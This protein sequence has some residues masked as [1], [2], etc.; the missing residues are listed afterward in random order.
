[1]LRVVVIPVSGYINRLQAIASA[2]LL[3]D[4]IGAEL[5]ICWI[6]DAVAPV[7][8]E[9]VL[10]ESLCAG[11]LV[12]A[13]EVLAMTGVNPQEVPRYLHRAG[14]TITL[15]GHDRGEQVFM[16]ELVSMLAAQQPEQLVIRA[17]GRY[18]LPLRGATETSFRRRRQEFYRARILA[19]A[20]EDE[21]ARQAAQHEP[22]IG[23]HLRYTDRAHQAPTT[24]AT[25]RALDQVVQRTGIRSV[26]IASDTSSARVSW[27]NRLRRQGL[28]PWT[29]AHDAWDRSVA[30]SEFSAMVDWRLLTRSLALIY[31]A[32]SS[33]A[34][35]AAVASPG[36]DLSVA[37]AP[38]PWRS[39]AV[40]GSTLLRAAVTYPHRHRWPGA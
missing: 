39:A 37:L 32:E 4:D 6:P 12:D 18:F 28:S 8:A 5:A 7:P 31:F 14:A 10:A 3:A 20:I 25:T 2:A 30:G 9:R 29:A 24:R 21:A 33:F 17:G 15:A 13:D 40:R 16:T 22:F 36:Y 34:V 1:V 11:R 27:M 35:E 23:V 26:F 38:S 19:T